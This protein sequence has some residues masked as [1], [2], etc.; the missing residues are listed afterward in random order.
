MTHWAPSGRWCGARCVSATEGPIESLAPGDLLELGV[1]VHECGR[2]AGHGNDP[3]TWEDRAHL[4]S[5]G[6]RWP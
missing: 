5:C 3:G 6:F 2:H 1:H 4:C